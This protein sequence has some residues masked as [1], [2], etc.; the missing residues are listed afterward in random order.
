M[1]ENCFE[2]IVGAENVLKEPHQLEV[3]RTG[4]A[5]P[6][7]SCAVR[8]GRTDEVLEIVRTA[9]AENIPLIP[10]SSGPPHFRGGIAPDTEKAVFVDLRRMNK[11]IRVDPANRVAIVEPGVTFGE[12]QAELEKSGLSAYMPL[13]PRSTK[14]VLAS[15]LERDPVIMPGVHFDST[16]PMLCAEIVFGSGDKMR[17]G[18][19]AGPDTLEEQWE[20]GK[21]QISPFGPTQMDPQ[22]LVSGA[23]GTIGIVTWISLKCRFL[24]TLSKSFFIPSDNLESLI[25]LTYYLTRIRFTG[26]IFLLNNTNLAC[27]SGNSAADI[28][29][30]R[31]DLP[32]WILYVSCEGY[33]PLPEEKVEYLETDLRE[34]AE[35]RRLVLHFNLSGIEAENFAGL[36]SRPSPEPYWKQRL[37]GNSRD[38]FFLTTLGNT[39]DFAKLTVEIAERKG[40]PAENIGT[41]IQPIVQGTSCHCEFNLFYDTSNRSEVNL[42]DELETEL[43]DLFEE[44]GAFF[45]RPYGKW[46]DI[47]YRRAGD[48]AEMQNRVKDIFDPNRILNP[49][50]LCF[51]Q[52][53][54]QEVTS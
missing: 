53:H 23:Q 7:G 24:S 9:N 8:P 34:L 13:L 25:D 28:T 44:R 3:Y 52:M 42:V 39:P 11:I 29:S 50:K 47:A 21:A 35:A 15:V 10:V 33:G 17:T 19:A 1:D 41:Y 43:I 38:I 27:L 54:N 32:P 26:N 37:K 36:L 40:F 45:S 46:V 2:K 12:L 31:K 14:S 18:E 49:G 48:T 6:A 22:R 51:G 4:A 30:L 5:L 16:D 20:I